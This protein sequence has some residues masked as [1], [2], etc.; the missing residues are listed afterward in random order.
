MSLIDYFKKWNLKKATAPKSG[1]SH[2]KT[3]AFVVQLHHASHLH[4]DFRPE[5]G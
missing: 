3:L 1:K 5:L 2:S 4:Y